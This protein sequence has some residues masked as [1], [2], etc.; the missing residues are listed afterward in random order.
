MTGQ[1]SE[2]TT[3][4][5]NSADSF[6]SALSTFA[7]VDPRGGRPLPGRFAEATADDIGA[8]ARGA[9]LAAPAWR[10]AD[11]GHRTQLLRAIAAE[12]LA[13]G[14]EL[15]ECFDAETALGVGRAVQERARTIAQLE[16]FAR[17][18]E[19]GDFLDVVIE[20]AQQTTSAGPRPDVRRM[21][22][23]VGPVLVMPPSNFPLAFG[24]AG[25]DT[26]SAL[27]VGC[28]VIVKGH[29]SH[30]ATSA[31]CAAAIGRAVAQTQA[32][33]GVFYL[34]QGRANVV[35]ERLVE[36]EEVKAVAFTG[37]ALAGR[38]LFDR[39]ASRPTPIPV[40]AEMG[41]VNP[42]F[43]TAAAS[44]A[45]APEIGETLA[46]S[47]LTANG[48]MCTK[49]GIVY[50]AGPGGACLVDALAVA[51]RRSPAVPLLNISV[52]AGFD[53]RGAEL[54]ASPGVAAIV[55][56]ATEDG[57]ARAPRL[58]ATDLQALRRHPAVAEE[59]FGPAA[60]V[61]RCETDEDLVK[62]ATEVAGSLTAT[63]FADPAANALD[64]VLRD[65]LEAK[66]G[67]LVFDGVPTG[68]A[69]G[70]SMHHGGPYPATT[71][72]AFTSVGDRAVQRFLRAV[73]YQDAPPALLPL[74][75]GDDNPLA[76][77]R[78]VDGVVEQGTHAARVDN[79]QTEGTE[80]Y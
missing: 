14:D 37:S 7:A 71:F 11:R 4:S 51:L 56:A 73:A 13:L 1:A 49:P 62:A 28:P 79:A 20:R 30:P 67:R 36:A 16:L 63:I 19:R 22:V 15:L 74:E 23:A 40:F 25:T 27:A 59:Q 21:M 64:S 68:V 69:V 39:A 60:V 2:K 53:R 47:I 3:S 55:D 29:P 76:I 38:A 72:P 32:P 61:V 31:M 6:Q 78:E 57:L 26:A 12:L 48:Q 44:A 43:V 52:A 33:P 54:R 10:R 18:A 45:R 66:A 58:S 77:R 8:A 70:A 65:E 35:A 50:V 42:V 17:V 24:V 34:L 75:L 41:S 9:A 80:C 5:L 46:A